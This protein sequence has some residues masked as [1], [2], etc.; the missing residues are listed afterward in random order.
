MSEDKP[1]RKRELELRFWKGDFTTRIYVKVK[2]A[3]GSEDLG[4]FERH[5][6]DPIGWQC[7]EPGR[8]PGVL[9]D[10]LGEQRLGRHAT[11]RNASEL[12]DHDPIW[13]A[14]MFAAGVR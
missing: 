10:I 4:Y 9:D 12:G 7:F 2:K 5:G 3:N 14:L 13:W 6:D 8:C 11:W 1:R